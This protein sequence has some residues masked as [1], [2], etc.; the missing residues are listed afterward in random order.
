MA[1]IS[2]FIVNGVR[3]WHYRNGARRAELTAGTENIVI[4]SIDFQ[5][6]TLSVWEASCVLHHADLQQRKDLEGLRE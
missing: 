3:H 5:Q 4:G 2:A 6:N 1:Q